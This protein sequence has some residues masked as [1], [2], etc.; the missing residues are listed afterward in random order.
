MSLVRYLFLG[1]AI[2][3]S[4][5]ISAQQS[6]I[7]FVDPFIG[8]DNKGQIFL[9]AS[10][11]FG[12]VKIGPDC[13]NKSANQ[14]YISNG[15]IRG[16]SHVHASGTGG[17]PKY[18]NVLVAPFSGYPDYK[19]YGTTGSQEVSTPG[20][21]S[22]FLDTYKIKSELAVTHSGAL[23]KY[24]YTSGKNNGF[25]IDLGSFLNRKCTNCIERQYLVG[26][27]I[28]LVNDTLIEG[29]TRVRGG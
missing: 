7:K 25:F 17:G 26:S 28:E 20:Y 6:L 24:T 3:T 21:F 14:G 1:F 9:G 18:G 22:V 4:M 16:F 27:S 5:V 19:N 15:I 8:V 11:P 10:L 13:N 2:L 29:Y 23:H 12:M